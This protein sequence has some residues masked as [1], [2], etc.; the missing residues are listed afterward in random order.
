MHMH[1][2]HA[3][4]PPSTGAQPAVRIMRCMHA[5]Q[6]QSEFTRRVRAL[7]DPVEQQGEAK[8]D[9]MLAGMLADPAAL[10]A[11]SAGDGVQRMLWL[12]VV[13]GQEGDGGAWRVS[14]SVCRAR[15]GG[16]RDSEAR[17]DVLLLPDASAPEG[18][19]VAVCA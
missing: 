11:S 5:G 13:S 15:V 18:F 1:C 3:W 19:A 12:D 8:E 17:H 4:R 2:A 6:L 14:Y 9:P 10:H 16:A 7:G